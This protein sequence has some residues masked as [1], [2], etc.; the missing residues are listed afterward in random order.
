MRAKGKITAWNDEKGFGFL[1][2]MTGGQPIFIHVTSFVNRNRLPEINETVTYTVSA[3]SQGRPCAIN[4][5]FSGE[6]LPLKKKRSYGSLSIMT[7]VIFIVVVAG[8]VLAGAIPFFVLAL[9]VVVSLLTCIVY[10]VD[11][12][13][14]RNGAW[15]T[16][17]DT[18]HLLS[19]AGGWPGAL[20]AQ[21]TLRHKSKKR[22]F[23]VKF[24][25]TVIINCGVF[26]WL[27]TPAGA[28]Q[29]TALIA[30]MA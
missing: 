21:Q 13:A 5:T 6:R 8:C 29:L 28:G 15:R 27:L 14:A 24:R 4:A 23:R 12:S 18:L 19:L 26:A 25:I 22:S 17:E 20:L 10:A 2:P 1:T 11:K 7:A 16:S 30:G 9:Y 3:A